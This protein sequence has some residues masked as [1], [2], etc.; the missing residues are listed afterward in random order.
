MAQFV[1]VHPVIYTAKL[2][3]KAHPIGHAAIA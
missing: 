1:S 2:Y 3:S